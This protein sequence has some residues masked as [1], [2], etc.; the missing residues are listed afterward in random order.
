MRDVSSL[1]G[2]GR[3]GAEKF[4]ESK[5]KDEVFHLNGEEKIDQDFPVGPCHAIGKKYGI[6]RTGGANGRGSGIPP[7][8][9]K[10]VHEGNKDT[11]TGS[12]IEII[13]E[14]A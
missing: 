10:K 12:G 2:S 9:Q 11:S 3:K 7:G 13:S 6:D 14:K 4:N 1:T 5:Y 8:G